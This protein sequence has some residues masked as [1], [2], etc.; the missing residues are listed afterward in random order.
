MPDTG[1][2]WNIPYVASTDLVS[3]W[4]A[5][6]LALANAIDSGLDAANAGI[7]TNVVQTVKTDTFSASLAGG[8]ET[9][10]T[11]LSVTITPTSASSLVLVLLSVSATSTDRPAVKLLRGGTAVFV[12]DAAGNRIR[13][14]AADSGS[15]A[16]E[17]AGSINFVGLDSPA[18]TSA[19]TYTVNMRHA[20][21]STNSV[22]VNRGA[23][24]TDAGRTQRTVSSITAIEVAA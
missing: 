19:T 16:P 5:D 7:G 18:T 8:A 13:M 11:G 1:A 4:P 10:I 14:T 17:N 24:D 3:D 9:T 23:T 2:P 15:N 20:S 21:S 22:Y 6:S 12:G